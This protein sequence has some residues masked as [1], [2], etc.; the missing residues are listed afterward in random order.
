MDTK[1]VNK[2]ST[3]IKNIPEKPKTYMKFADCLIKND[4]KCFVSK[5]ELD[6]FKYDK[7]KNKM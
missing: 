4:K 6:R 5:N 7:K 2:S 3:K 1:K